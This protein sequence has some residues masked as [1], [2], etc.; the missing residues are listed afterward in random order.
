MAHNSGASVL[1]FKLHTKDIVVPVITAV[2][3]RCEARACPPDGAVVVTTLPG[4]ASTPPHFSASELSQWFDKLIYNCKLCFC[5][6]LF[7]GR[8]RGCDF[9]QPL[10]RER[11][12]RTAWV[13]RTSCELWNVPLVFFFFSSLHKDFLDTVWSVFNVKIQINL[14]KSIWTKQWILKDLCYPSISFFFW[15]QPLSEITIWIKFFIVSNE[16]G[17]CVFLPQGSPGPTGVQGPLGPS[18]PRGYEVKMTATISLFLLF[19]IKLR[20]FLIPT[21][22]NWPT[23]SCSAVFFQGP[24]GAPGPPGPKVSPSS[25][26]DLALP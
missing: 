16:H 4:C 20:R 12:N 22:Y 5:V 2:T 15:L 17:L 14:K 23:H 21:R 24:P 9:H 10:W 13:T 25:S 1:L 18:G 8:P 7:A 3:L 26:G 11:S 6:F 19:L